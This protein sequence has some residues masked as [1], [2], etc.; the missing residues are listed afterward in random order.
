LLQSNQVIAAMLTKTGSTNTITNTDSKSIPLGSGIY[1]L[2][3]N[4]N[5]YIA[6]VPSILTNLKSGGLREALGRSITGLFNA[7]E[8]VSLSGKES[9]TQFN[10][11]EP[12][13]LFVFDSLSGR[14]KKSNTFIGNP[15]R[16]NE[17]FL[18]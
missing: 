11:N 3:P 1:Y 14:F 12:L 9:S 2:D 6:L 15:Q 16:S 8:K 10:T 7:K 5:E 18:I 17:F 13:F 4:K